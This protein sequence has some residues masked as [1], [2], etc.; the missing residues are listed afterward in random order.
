MCQKSSFEIRITEI[1]FV[2]LEET[3]HTNLKLSVSYCICTLV[4]FFINATHVFCFALNQVSQITACRPNPAHETFTWLRL[5]L[6]I[7]KTTYEKFVDLVGCNI[8]WNNHIMQDVWPWTIAYV[9]ILKSSWEIPAVNSEVMSCNKMSF[10][11]FFL[12]QTLHIELH[13]TTK[14]SS[15]IFV[16]TFYQNMQHNVCAK[17]ARA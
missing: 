2:M 8:S 9:A 10:T 7:I 15:M 3:F 1:L 17:H 11:L 13:S 12:Q 16:Q 4:Y 14:N 6:S 5:H